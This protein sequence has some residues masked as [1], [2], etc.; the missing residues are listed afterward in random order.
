MRLAARAFSALFALAVLAF[1]ASALWNTGP[2]PRNAPPTLD[3][4]RP[5][6]RIVIDKSARRLTV[7]QGG[8]ARASFP[9]ALGFTPEGDKQREGDGK[10]PEGLFRINR[11]N[12]ASAYHLSLG[13]DYPQPDDVARARAAG[14]S[15]G[16]NI[17][18]HGQPNSIG[19][20][21]TLTHDWT[22]GCIAVSNAVIEDLWQIVPIGTPVEIRP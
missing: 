2:P 17:F 13:I 14:V 4:S 1:V 9:I 6:E 19:A 11:R 15:P 7:F 10:T 18:I 22:A 5:A 8:D 16:G 12:G 3:L 20:R 21:I